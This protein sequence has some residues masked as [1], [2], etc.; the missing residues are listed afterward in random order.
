M[1]KSQHSR[2][3]RQRK[4]IEDDCFSLRKHAAKNGQCP[5]CLGDRVGIHDTSEGWLRCHECDAVF[6]VRNNALVFLDAT[7]FL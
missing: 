7:K 5:S 3:Q 1:V 6:R 4:Q 2:L